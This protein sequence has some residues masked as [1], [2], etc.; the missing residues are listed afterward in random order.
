MVLRSEP[1]AS[2]LSQHKCSDCERVML[3]ALM[4]QFS[5]AAAPRVATAP[6]PIDSPHAFA[7]LFLLSR[8]VNVTY[9]NR[10]AR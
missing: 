8:R 2:R 5:P 3:V 1:E 4:A 10:V 7:E 9:R 6:L